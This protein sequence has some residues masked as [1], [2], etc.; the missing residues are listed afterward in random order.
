MKSIYA[1]LQHDSNLTS[2]YVVVKYTVANMRLLME[3]SFC[4]FR[5]NLSGFV[6]PLLTLK[7]SQTTPFERVWVIWVTDVK[8]TCTYVTTVSTARKSV[9]SVI[10][11]KQR[12]VTFFQILISF[13]LFTV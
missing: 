12:F 6:L 3:N 7:Q 10:F 2:S 13:I 5:F 8:R 4:S 9:A 1:K 11:R